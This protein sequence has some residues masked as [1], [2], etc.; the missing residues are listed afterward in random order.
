[1]DYQAIDVS[2]E[3]AVSHY[4]IKR[5]NKPGLI[6]VTLNM[7]GKHNILNSLA[8]FAVA[9]EDGI[10]APAL[11]ES[12]KNFSGIGRRF[13]ICGDFETTA[14]Q[15]KLID[16]YG[17][18]P[19]EIAATIDAVKQGWSEKRLVMVFQPHRYT[20]TRDLFEDFVSVL[21]K[22]DV[23]IML[24]VYSAGEA[25]IS[26]ADG[27]SLCRSIRQRGHLDPIFVNEQKELNTALADIVND[28]DIIVT[29]G[30]GNVG[31]IAKDWFNQKL[32]FIDDL[33]Q[34]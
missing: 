1:M 9:N 17:H 14:G 16:D 5:R 26:G 32:A 12:L 2:Q 29:Q 30:A 22:V 34:V 33:R 23:L 4:K 25:V 20:R 10:R 8:A 11:V 21:N 7:P 31:S 28:G 6:D 3:G 19:T 24:E 18:H 15:L 27:R 13:Q